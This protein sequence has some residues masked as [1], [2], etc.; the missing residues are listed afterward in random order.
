MNWHWLQLNGARILNTPDMQLAIRGV[1]TIVDA[2]AIG[3]FHGAAGLGK[4][5]SLRYAGRRMSKRRGIPVTTVTLGEAPNQN[6]MLIALL[7]AVTGVP[8]DGVRRQLARD[9]TA[10]LEEPRLLIV[11]EAQSM[12]KRCLET[13]RHIHDDERTQFSLALVGGNGCWEVLSQYPMLERRVHVRI[14]FRPLSAESVL[15][16]MPTYHAVY[17]SVDLELLLHVDEL[18]G[19][20]NLG[21]WAD[22]TVHAVRECANR[23]IASIN[24]EVVKA[25]FAMKGGRNAA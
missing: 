10:V 22:F 24:A 1:E 19:H 25:V 3:A 21:H 8:N 9:L 13:L 7:D 14:P 11:D 18:Y 15:K 5:F 23:D 4:T 12:N 2:K 16:L 6:D 17:T 20:G